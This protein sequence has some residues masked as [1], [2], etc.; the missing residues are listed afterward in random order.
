MAADAEGEEF[1]FRAGSRRPN[2]MFLAIHKA[3]Q[4]GHGEHHSPFT[5]PAHERATR[6]SGISFIVAHWISV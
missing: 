3:R 2:E 4:A 1:R 5:D 6:Q